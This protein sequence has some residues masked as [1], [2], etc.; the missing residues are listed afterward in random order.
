MEI[1]ND[2]LLFKS[3]IKSTRYEGFQFKILQLVQ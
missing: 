1:F 3:K 2:S